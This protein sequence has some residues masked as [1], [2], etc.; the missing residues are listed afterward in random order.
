LLT[1]IPPPLTNGCLEDKN[2]R[3]IFFGRNLLGE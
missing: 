3:T 2:D 1:F